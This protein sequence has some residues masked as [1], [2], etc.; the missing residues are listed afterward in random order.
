MYKMFDGISEFKV[1]FTGSAKRQVESAVGII[2]QKKKAI[3][4]TED[5]QTPYLDSIKV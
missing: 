4:A 3:Y 1:I 2:E 5:N